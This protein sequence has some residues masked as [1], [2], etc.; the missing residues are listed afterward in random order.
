MSFDL[1]SFFLLEMLKTPIFFRICEMYRVCVC[2]TVTFFP[3]AETEVSFV[4]H[5][6]NFLSEI[7]ERGKISIRQIVA[8]KDSAKQFFLAFN[9][10]KL[11]AAVRQMSPPCPHHTRAA[12]RHRVC[13]AYKYQLIV[14]ACDRICRTVRRY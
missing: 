11:P 6:L 12:L 3:E 5:R 1:K 2:V 8:I 14:V 7:S 10:F 13:L 9:S 4:F